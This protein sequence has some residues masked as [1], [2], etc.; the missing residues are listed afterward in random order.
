MNFA[1]SAASAPQRIGPRQGRDPQ[2]SA[3]P[4]HTNAIDATICI[5]T[6]IMTDSSPRHRTGPEHDA[7]PS[8]ATR[9]I[10]DVGAVDDGMG[11]CWIES[12]T[13]K[14]Q[15]GASSNPDNSR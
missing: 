4:P 10:I 9:R 7:G 12:E 1:Q 13:C 3:L 8:H 2:T 11:G 6:G 15:Q 14:P 5:A